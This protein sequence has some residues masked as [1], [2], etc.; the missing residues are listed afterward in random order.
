MRVLYVNSKVFHTCR[1][2]LPPKGAQELDESGRGDISCAVAG[3]QLRKRDDYGGDYGG[4]SGGDYGDFLASNHL[5]TC[6]CG[7]GAHPASQQWL[8]RESHRVA[9]YVEGAVPNRVQWT[10]N[11]CSVDSH[12]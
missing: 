12:P 1:R 3:R 2:L 6:T 7:G 4:D 9:K 11:D 5:F 10:A 8:V